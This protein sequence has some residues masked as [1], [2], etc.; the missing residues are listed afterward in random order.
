M[1]EDIQ[2]IKTISNQII[3]K[4]S[5][6]LE[7]EKILF[8][9]NES[10]E[11]LLELVTQ[12]LESI[13][14]N[15]EELTKSL[16]QGSYPIKL[17]K[18]IA[19]TESL[20][21]PKI[22]AIEIS[23]SQL[24]QIYNEAVNLLAGYAIKVSLTAESYREPNAS[25]IILETSDRGN[26]WVIATI[27]QKEQ[28]YW[29][30]P[31]GKILLDIHRLKTIQTLFQLEG[32]HS[33]SEAEFY[34]QQPAILS[35]LPNGRQW[36]LEEQGI[37]VFG[38]YSKLSENISDRLRIEINNQILPLIDKLR[39]NQQALISTVE[40]SNTQVSQLE[41]QL[42][43][44]QQDRHQEKQDWLSEKQN[45][46]EQ[47]QQ[48]TSSTSHAQNIVNPQIEQLTTK[49]SQF[50]SQLN[51]VQQD[52]Q[53][54]KQDWL[55]EKQNLQEQLQQSKSHAQNIFDSQFGIIYDYNKTSIL[56]KAIATVSI[57][58]KS[59]DNFKIRNNNQI[60]F[61]EIE[62]GNYLILKEE[63][64]NYLIPRENFRVAES[65]FEILQ[66]LFICIGYE[67][68]YSDFQI[69]KPAK[70]SKGSSGVWQLQE[71]GILVFAKYSKPSETIGDCPSIEINNQ[72][73]STV[74][75]LL[76]NQ[77]NL[78]S[79]VEQL[80]T[81]VSQLQSELD[82]LQ[83]DHDRQKKD[84]FTHTQ[85]LQNKLQ[86]VVRSPKQQV[87]SFVEQTIQEGK[88]KISSFLQT[89]VQESQS[90]KLFDNNDSNAL[91]QFISAYN[92]DKKFVL[93]QIIA[94][95][96]I[97]LESF[98]K[99]ISGDRSM[100]TLNETI[101]GNYWIIEL[102]GVFYLV[103]SDD[104]NNSNVLLALFAFDSV[105]D[106][107]DIRKIQLIQPAKVSQ[108]SPKTWKLEEKGQLKFS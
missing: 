56:E 55:S 79:T 36:R 52:R 17:A 23:T 27:E 25:E 61:K 41:S 77:Q 85:E 40:R 42:N 92:Q 48:S 5:G 86:E 51:K 32:K 29:L 91:S 44:V 47:F 13:E 99:I 1:S 43:K 60:E 14:N 30:V 24:V 26:Y 9:Q 15:F 103:P 87:N 98:D 6:I 19:I 73:S 57:T 50:E 45:L 53:Q 22:N 96:T 95:V 70:V 68:E 7:R 31:N 82:K 107:K 100:V 3:N 71:Q 63:N 54:E 64:M 78:L 37:L 74:E 88:Q 18:A 84:W 59:W 81:K 33:S 72:I 49:V 83:Q 89:T 69:I 97:S 35:L 90:T 16:A 93:K 75:K 102:S 65:K 12:K 38:K 20:V 62:Q 76:S 58:Q 106:Y 66:A 34:L 67:I 46:Q 80:I 4:I 2:A 105:K 39:S 10:Q 8:E 108:L 21:I 28:K 104:R 94:K 11:E 101:N